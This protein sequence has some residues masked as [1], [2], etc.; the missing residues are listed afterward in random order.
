MLEPLLILLL[1]ALMIAIIRGDIEGTDLDTPRY[2][3]DQ[4]R[5]IDL[6]RLLENHYDH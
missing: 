6:L 3:P 4:I 5:N 1:W 2:D